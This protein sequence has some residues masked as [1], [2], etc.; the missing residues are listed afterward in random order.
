MYQLSL[1]KANRMSLLQHIK[2][3]AVGLFRLLFPRCCAV[4]GV[5]LLADEEALCT[6]CNIRMPRTHYDRQADNPAARTFWGK[7]P[8][9]RASAYFFYTKGGR[10]RRIVLRIK[11]HGERQLGETMGRFMAAELMQSDFFAGIDLLV[12]VPLHPRKLRRRGYNQSECI[13]RGVS[14][15]TSIPVDATSLVRT[16]NN[17]SQTH[18]PGAARWDNVDGIFA[19][20][21]PEC[22]AGRHIL[23]IDDVLTTGATLTAC[24]DACT[25]APGIR[26]SVLA[27]S[28]AER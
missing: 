19:L 5:P 13:A 18:H 10:Y 17:P 4:C 12:P 21:H 7:F 14:Q 9:G 6:T 2:Q 15:V 24:A 11:Y 28:M 27:L 3:G 26:I 25:A 1:T 23:L 22:L 20:S 8:F 16:H